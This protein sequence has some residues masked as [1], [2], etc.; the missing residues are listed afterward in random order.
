MTDATKATRTRRPVRMV[1]T[2]E[3]EM[4]IMAGSEEGNNIK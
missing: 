4:P 3:K 1:M 2:V